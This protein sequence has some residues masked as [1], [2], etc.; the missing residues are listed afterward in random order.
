MKPRPFDPHHLDLPVFC[1]VGATLSGEWPQAGFARLAEDQRP[2][3]GDATPAP[4]QWQARG[5]LRAVKGAAPELWL[6][7]IGQTVVS[8]E[9]QR[10]LQPMSHPLAVERRLRFVADEDQ[11]AELD[12][13]SEDD[14]L[15]LPRRLDVQVLLED[16][17]ILALPLV[18]RHDRCPAPLA[19][20]LGR[21]AEPDPPGLGGAEAGRSARPNPFAAL[22]ALRGNAGDAESADEPGHGDPEGEETP[23]RR[24]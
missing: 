12:E 20:D 21:L 23:S 9:C 10:C 3:E 8:L 11:A 17:L 4:V 24:H 18:P 2:A 16:E 5:E 6:H 14:V 15:A 13:E 7:L 19:P 1:R 22:A